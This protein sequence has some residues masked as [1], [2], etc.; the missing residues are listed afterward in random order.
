METQSLTQYVK[1]NATVVCN[2]NDFYFYATVTVNGEVYKGMGTNES[3][4]IADLIEYIK[5]NI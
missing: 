1:D 2:E 4:A 5:S 3:L